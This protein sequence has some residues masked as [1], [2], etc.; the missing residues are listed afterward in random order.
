M[1][2]PEGCVNRMY[3]RLRQ[4]PRGGS[5]D[6][7]PIAAQER[8]SI[9]VSQLTFLA[10]PETRRAAFLVKPIGVGPFPGILY[11]H[12][13]E[14][15][16]ADSN[17]TQFLSEAEEMAQAGAISLLI[18][19][20]WSDREWFLK[21]TQADDVRQS[22]E[23]VW[24]IRRALDLLLEQPEADSNRVAYVG[25]DFGA[26]YGI[27]AGSVDSRP[28]A[29][30]LMAGTPRL[31]DWYLY[32]PRLDEPER[33]RFVESIRALDPVERVARL[34]PASLLFQFGK[35][36]PHVPMDRARSFFAAASKPKRVG[37]YDA[38]HGLNAQAEA[39]RIA[40]VSEQLGLG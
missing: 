18:E 5:L 28:H 26:M 15:E 40:W 1:S 24:E 6:V 11:V 23:V 20:A 7:R 33:S 9:V 32:Y 34:A 35:S 12:W 30:A 31:S 16:A 10:R 17:R 29:Y 19:A 39:D 37:W 4:A 22:V 3:D 8:D 14:P 2:A 21:R 36:D 13:Y 38:E 27:V 25:H